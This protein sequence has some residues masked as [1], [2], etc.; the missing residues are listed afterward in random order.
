MRTKAAVSAGSCKHRAKYA[1]Y[2]NES[3]E[4]APL[5]SE[6]NKEINKD[7]EMLTVWGP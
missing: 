1:V 7:L 3:C 4:D 5:E 2:F 6:A